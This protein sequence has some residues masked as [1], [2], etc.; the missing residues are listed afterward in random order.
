MRGAVCGSRVDQPPA[1]EARPGYGAIRAAASRE[2]EAYRS[3]LGDE[4]L[5][6]PATGRLGYGAGRSPFGILGKN[7]VTR[8]SPAPQAMAIP[9]I[10]AR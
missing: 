8:K 9:A 5:V 6:P 10:K 2:R 4:Q 7:D 1:A 3:A